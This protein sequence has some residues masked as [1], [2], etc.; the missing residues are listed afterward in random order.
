MQE[1]SE[2]YK[3]IIASPNHRYETKVE[4]EEHA[5][6][7]GEDD[8]PI[9]VITERLLHHVRRE[10]PGMDGHQPTVG[11]AFAASQ[12][13]EIEGLDWIFNPMEE[14]DVYVRAVGTVDGAQQ[15]SEW[16]PQ[17][18]YFLDTR[19]YSEA[20]TVRITAYDAMLKTEK[21]Y[22]DTNHAWPYKDIDVLR[23]IAQDIEVTLDP[24]TVEIVTAGLMIELPADY[25]EREVLGMIASAYV[26][27][28]VITDANKL[29]L[30]PIYG[31]DDD[32]LS[33]NYLA[34][35]DGTTAL[36]MG[37]EGWFILV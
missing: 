8:V 6:L 30:V 4:T 19:E 32:N 7:F 35:D 29:L 10:K 17:G 26:G 9:Y 15:T 37:D 14:F 36:M 34:D 12:D 5:S 20:G 33:G 27:N 2:L 24:R 23:E 11:N 1:T 18:V 28:F 21:P 25:T 31:T 22:P 13:M 16:I 3:Q